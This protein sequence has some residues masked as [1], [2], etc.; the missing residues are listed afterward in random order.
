MK[1]FKK[2]PLH[3]ERERKMKIT[4]LKFMSIFSSLLVLSSLMTGCSNKQ[5][6]CDDLL[7][8]LGYGSWN[9]S[10]SNW[11]DANCR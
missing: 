10:D 2:T 4:K 7:N 5:A 3:N 1:A 11:Y 9:E 6:K 8:A